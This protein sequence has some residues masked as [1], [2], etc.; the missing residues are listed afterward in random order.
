MSVFISFPLLL[1]PARVPQKRATTKLSIPEGCWACS[2][3]DMYRDSARSRYTLSPK[4]PNTFWTLSILFPGDYCDEHSVRP[5]ETLWIQLGSI[6]S[7]VYT[8]TLGTL[9]KLYSLAQSPNLAS[10]WD[11]HLSTS[12]PEITSLVSSGS[13]QIGIIPDL[14]KYHNAIAT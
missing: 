3:D 11:L 7:T 14:S 12:T 8:D 2:T 1:N 5:F 9:H 10:W 6:K 4:L 13:L